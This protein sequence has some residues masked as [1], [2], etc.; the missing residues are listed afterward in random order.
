[1]ESAEKSAIDKQVAETS[2]TRIAALADLQDERW[3]DPYTLSKKLRK[4]HRAEKRVIKAKEESDAALRAKLGLP[5]DLKFSDDTET[6]KEEARQAWE[7]AKSNLADPD[8]RKRKRLEITG[9]SLATGSS[10]RK[11][12]SVSSTSAK[13]DLAT[14][15]AQQTRQSASGSIFGSNSSSSKTSKALSGIIRTSK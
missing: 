8:H 15:L 11:A 5:E 2:K 12:P 13:K 10:K 7:T 1:M 3:S 9:S 6:F 14:R 4:S